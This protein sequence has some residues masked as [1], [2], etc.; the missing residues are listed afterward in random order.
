MT[1]ETRQS[2]SAANRK[3][4]TPEQDARRRKGLRSANGI[5]NWFGYKLF[6]G[7]VV[8]L[9]RIMMQG[10][11]MYLPRLPQ[12]HAHYYPRFYRRFSGKPISDSAFVVAPNH[13]H[14]LDI[15]LTGYIRRPMAWPSKPAFVKWWILKQ[16]NQRV[17][18]VPF[19][20][21]VDWLKNPEYAEITYTKD[22]LKDVMYEDLKLGQPVVLY[23]QGTRKEDANFE[24]SQLGAMY[25]AIRANVP[26]VPLA[27]YGLTKTDQHFRTRFL[28]RHRAVAI[29]MD[30]IYPDAYMHLGDHRER[31][32]AMC[33]AWRAAIETG[34]E[35][36]LR[37][38]QSS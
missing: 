22:E 4:L 9:S 37:R 32:R 30:S 1:D 20:R 25:A 21:D 11:I 18:C 15:A 6:R 17:G 31:A 33:V 13:S 24:D 7:M 23:P 38:L 27:I 10:E 35:E 8:L 29:V 34:R 28:K 5:G 19:M 14:M 2:S 16:I 12:P 3:P 36:G 26:L